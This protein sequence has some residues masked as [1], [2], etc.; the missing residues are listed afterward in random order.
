MKVA[1]AHVARNPLGVAV[2]LAIASQRDPNELSTDRNFERGLTPGV[3]LP[4]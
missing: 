3:M 2:G 4:W 1:Q